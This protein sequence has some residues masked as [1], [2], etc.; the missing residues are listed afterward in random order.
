MKYTDR[1]LPRKVLGETV[2]NS[3]FSPNSAIKLMD[4]FFW[5]NSNTPWMSKAKTTIKINT[6][7]SPFITQQLWVRV[8]I[9]L[10]VVFICSLCHNHNTEHSLLWIFLNVAHNASSNSFASNCFNEVK[11][12][13]AYRKTHLARMLVDNHTQMCFGVFQYEDVIHCLNSLLIYSSDI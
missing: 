13:R 11:V 9:V 2:G 5:K 3:H 7:Y 8:S 12:H 6:L 4:K 10:R 1:K